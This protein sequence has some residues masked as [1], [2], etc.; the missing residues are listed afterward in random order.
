MQLFLDTVNLADLNFALEVK[1]GNTEWS[2]RKDYACYPA[3]RGPPILL[4][5][6]CKIEE[7]L[8]AGF[9]PA[10]VGAQLVVK[11]LGFDVILGSRGFYCA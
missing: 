6:S 3:S 4:D 7:S 1:L 10:C 8:L 11:L 5:K 9:M 2:N